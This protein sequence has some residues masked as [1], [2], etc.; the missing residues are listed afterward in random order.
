MCKPPTLV[1]LVTVLKIK[2]V[3]FLLFLASNAWAVKTCL[4]V[5]SRAAQLTAEDSRNKAWSEWLNS[6][7]SNEPNSLTNKE[8]LMSAL[9][10]QPAALRFFKFLAPDFPETIPSFTQLQKRFIDYQR[11]MGRTGKQIFKLAR[12]VKDPDTKKLKLTQGNEATNL[13]KRFPIA[14]SVY[15]YAIAHRMVPINDSGLIDV[16]TQNFMLLH[17]LGHAYSLTLPEYSDFIFEITQRLVQDKGI[18]DSLPISDQLATFIGNLFEDF[19]ILPQEVRPDFKS[20]VLALEIELQTMKQKIN[21]H[22]LPGN[23]SHLKMRFQELS[24]LIANFHLAFGGAHQNG[25]DLNRSNYSTGMDLRDPHN[26]L[27]HFDYNLV[28]LEQMSGS[29]ASGQIDLIMGFYITPL[30]ELSERSFESSRAQ[31]LRLS[32]APKR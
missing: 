21:A 27:R 19:W 17:D 26:F 16:Q 22:E 20:K 3:L 11:Q 30:K 18:Q 32:Q 25:I 14:D 29:S 31:F 7:G 24:D 9:R 4:S 8:I 15:W 28:R 23:T 1:N 5:S 13:P 12:I 10:Q 6:S 2:S